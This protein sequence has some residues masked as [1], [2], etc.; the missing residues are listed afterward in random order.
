M[1]HF[2]SR[3]SVLG[4]RSHGFTL[5]ELLVVIAIIAILAAILFPVFAQAKEAAKR[6]QCLSNMKQAGTAMNLY[7]SDSDDVAPSVVHLGGGADNDFYAI[8][9]PYVKNLDMFYCPDRK[10]WSMPTGDDCSG[11]SFNTKQQC[12]GYGF[13]WGITSG[14]RTAMVGTRIKFSGGYTEPGIPLSSVVYSS[15][16]F[17]YGDTGDNPRYTIC[18]NYIVQYY[19][20][21]KSNNQLRHGGHFNMNYLDGHAKAVFFKAGF[22]TGGNLWG[23]P[24]NPTDQLGYCADPDSTNNTI[25][26]LTCTQLGQYI[27]SAYGITWFK[28]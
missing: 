10:E 1:N 20:N 23:F 3:K 17:V 12:I 16:V 14:T 8:L 27:N 2:N 25:A 28:D 7:V 9:Q 13:N 19:T 21:T 6:T 24:K 15:Q 22:D 26:G 11:Q 4:R 5:I 18:P